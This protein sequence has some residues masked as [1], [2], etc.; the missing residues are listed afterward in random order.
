MIF[1]KGKNG[2]LKKNV[3]QWGGAAAPSESATGSQ[4]I[5]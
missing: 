3:S 2:F 4:G 1:K 5:F